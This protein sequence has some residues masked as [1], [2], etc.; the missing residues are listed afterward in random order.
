MDFNSRRLV[1]LALLA[2]SIG[3]LVPGL[4]HPVIAAAAMAVSSVSVVGNSLRLRRF[5]GRAAPV[6]TG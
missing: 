6:T 1:I 3:L 2:I 4:L 5:G